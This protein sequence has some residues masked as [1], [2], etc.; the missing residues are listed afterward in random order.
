[1]KKWNIYIIIIVLAAAL[2]GLS[3][4]QSVYIK[5]GFIVQ[6]QIFNQYVN[7]AMLRT[8]MRIEEDQTREMFVNPKFARLFNQ[9]KQLDA[10]N[11]YS[12]EYQ[13]GII[14]LDVVSGSDNYQFRGF[15]MQQID[16]LIQLSNLNTTL[17]KG[18]NRSILLEY[19]VLM[20]EFESQ[21][22]SNIRTNELYDSSK[23]YKQLDFELNRIGI[24][25]SFEFAL[26]DAF[27]MQTIASNFKSLNENTFQNSF[28]TGV[29]SNLISNND[30]ILLANFPK[31]NAFLLKSNRTL[32]TS[33][34]IFIFL[35][36]ASFVA[37]ILIIF[38]QKQLSEL[39][40][41]FINNMTH[42]LKTP[43]ATIS[44]ASEMIQN[45]KVQQSLDKLN[46]YTKIIRSE[47]KRL[48]NHIE[49]VLHI[50]QLEKEELKLKQETI[51]FKKLLD[52]VLQKFQLRIEDVNGIFIKEIDPTNIFVKA[53]KSHISNVISNLIDNAIKYKSNKPLRIEINLKKLKNNLELSIKDNGI[54][55]NS[56]EAKK[57][58]TKFYRVPTGN[59]HNVKGFGLGLSYAKTIVDAHKGNIEVSSEP[60]KFSI[61]K[62]ILPTIN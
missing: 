46:N 11:G 30:A 35:I 58:F 40:T 47:N 26:L 42:E 6:D 50:A 57:I 32:L 54:G 2:I 20:K 29:N 21:L 61:F 4:V 14:T 56:A 3:Y 12:I 15:N 16:S 33:S 55:M 1:M 41:D 7:E 31:K 28:K 49:R 34:F 13:N 52:E 23:I 19:E 48:G 60:N 53:D 45:P 39:K 44:L 38:R 10:L 22:P 51:D 18:L 43:V 5:R 17:K 62:L 9:V 59:V 27:S 25:T 24:K 37:S 36:I 8:A